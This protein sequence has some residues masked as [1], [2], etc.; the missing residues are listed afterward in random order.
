[1][2]CYKRYVQLTFMRGTSLSPIP[3]TS[4]KT[5]GARY[6][7]IHEGCKLEEDQIEEWIRQ[8]SRLPGVTL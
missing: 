4:S 2:Y 3:P 8:A 1:M 6:L 5:E 7:N